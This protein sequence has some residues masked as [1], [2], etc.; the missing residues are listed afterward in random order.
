MP[1]EDI[2]GKRTH[3]LKYYNGQ[4]LQSCQEYTEFTTLYFY[5]IIARTVAY[6]ISLANGSEYTLPQDKSLLPC[7]SSG[8]ERDNVRLEF[9]M[10]FMETR[11]VVER[12]I[13]TARGVL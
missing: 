3:Y 11:G 9:N 8:C 6:L 13:Y 12:L 7:P 1:S 4:N 2:D 5:V 10:C